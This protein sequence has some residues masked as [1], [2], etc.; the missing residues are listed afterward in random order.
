MTA[1][2]F[3]AW[4][5]LVCYEFLIDFSCSS[6]SSTESSRLYSYTELGCIVT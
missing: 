1:G 6:H 5:D 3:L 4:K 2:L